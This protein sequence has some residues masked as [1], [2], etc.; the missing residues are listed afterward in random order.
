MPSITS[1]RG[2][3]VFN[4][5]GSKTIEIDVVTDGKFIGRA[6]APSGAS[7]GKFEAQSFPQNKPEEAFCMLD[8]NIN[9]F[10]GLQAENL[11]AVYN[12]L[13]SMDKTDN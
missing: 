9:K 11:Q 6:C 12:A 7:V 3:I 2:R 10:V 8:A 4:S 5:R 1:I 13:R